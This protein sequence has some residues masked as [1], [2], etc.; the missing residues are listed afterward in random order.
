MED[1]QLRAVLDQLGREDEVLG[2]PGP[3]RGPVLVD[4]DVGERV[5]D[6]PRRPALGQLLDVG[7]RA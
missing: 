4:G 2:G 5:D 3:Q 7:R 1:V 6:V